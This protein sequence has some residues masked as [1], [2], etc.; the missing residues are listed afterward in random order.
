[1]HL[2]DLMWLES[3][4]VYK[5]VFMSISPS[6]LAA[7]IDVC[8]YGFKQQMKRKIC[9]K[10][11]VYYHHFRHTHA[12]RTRRTATALDATLT[13]FWRLWNSIKAVNIMKTILHLT[14]LLLNEM[15]VYCIHRKHLKARCPVKEN[16]IKITYVIKF[17]FLMFVLYVHNHVHHQCP[18]WTPFHHHQQ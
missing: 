9:M 5:N 7:V 10:I 2:G 6:S 17:N 16:E 1:M 4:T 14:S 11:Y 3:G 15:C 12:R 8:T 13:S 18:G